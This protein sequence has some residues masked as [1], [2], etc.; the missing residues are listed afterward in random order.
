MS[1][2][3]LTGNGSQ[4]CNGNSNMCMNENKKE[5]NNNDNKRVSFSKH[6]LMH[7]SMH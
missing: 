3:I 4:L 7:I 5:E 2:S 1:N 6:T